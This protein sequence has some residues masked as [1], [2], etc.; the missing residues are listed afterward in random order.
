MLERILSKATSLINCIIFH[1]PKK[2]L[3]VKEKEMVRQNGLIHFT[4]SEN[5]EKILCEGVRGGIKPPMKKIENG[6]TWYFLYDKKTFNDKQQIIH[7]K[8]ERKSYDVFIVIK[9]LSEKQINELRIGWKVNDAIIYPGD[10]KTN[11]MTAYYID[12]RS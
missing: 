5:V 7:G 3:N 10:L 4:N 2:E 1:T 6:Y 8:G 9:G 12:T 11:D